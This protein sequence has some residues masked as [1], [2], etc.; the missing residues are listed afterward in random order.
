MIVSIMQP[1]YMPWLGYFDRIFRSDIH[2]VLDHVS[3]DKNS[4]TKFTNRNKIRTSQGWSWMTCPINSSSSGINLPINEIEIVRDMSWRSK[5]LRSLEVNYASAP[6]FRKHAIFFE[7]LYRYDWQLL[8]PLLM[9]ST[10][11]LLDELSIDTQILLSSNMSPRLKKSDLILELCKKVGAKTYLSG[12]FGRDYLNLEAFDANG[13]D[14]DFHE[15]VHPTYRQ[16][17]SGFESHMSV[18][19][20]LFNY[21]PES[22]GIIRS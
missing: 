16:I 3:M 9:K 22:L 5:H 12:P 1:A 15:Y 2:I 19:D 21:G 20:L 6:F 14:V 18:V 17:F 10:Q 13:I 4:K 7:E 8:S 11:Y